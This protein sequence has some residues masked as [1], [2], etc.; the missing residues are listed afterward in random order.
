VA[1][2]GRKSRASTTTLRPVSE[3][4]QYLP[5]NEKRILT[6][7]IAQEDAAAV[8]SLTKSEMVEFYTTY[9][10]PASPQRAKLAV[11][12]VAQGV[13]KKTEEA[14]TTDGEAEQ[15]PGNGS[16]PCVIENVRDYKAGLVASAGARPI[17][18]L[19]EFEDFD[20]K[21]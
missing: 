7:C 2:T 6:L 10:I 8:K 20:P 3:F 16:E 15:V 4:Q 13:S 19:N 14:A 1:D 21:L 5:C 18:E 17:K 9:I 11:H 12:L